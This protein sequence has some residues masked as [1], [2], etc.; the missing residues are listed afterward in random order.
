MR[1]WIDECIPNIFNSVSLFYLSY[2]SISK[3]LML[4]LCKLESRRHMLC[5]WF[6]ISL[7]QSCSAPCAYIPR[8]NVASFILITWKMHWIFTGLFF[9]EFLLIFNWKST[10]IVCCEYYIYACRYWLC[11]LLQGNSEVSLCMHFSKCVNRGWEEEWRVYVCKWLIQKRLVMSP[12]IR[13]MFN[14]VSIFTDKPS[15]A[16]TC[17]LDAYKS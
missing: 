11:G 1:K 15:N 12:Y 10:G 6:L 16:R 5:L 14:D 3:F 13:D 4:Q 9:L 2:P 7:W 8:Q 17:I